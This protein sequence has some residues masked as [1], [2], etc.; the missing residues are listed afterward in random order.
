MSVS[1]SPLSASSG[2][3]QRFSKLLER[4]QLTSYDRTQFESHRTTVR[5]AIEERL[6][7]SKVDLMGSFA[8]GTAIHGVSDVDLLVVLRKRTLLW[9]DHLKTSNT[10]LSEVREAI[11]D[12]FPH[13][14]VSRDCQ[15]IVAAFSDGT[16][17]V[18]IVPAYYEDQAGEQNNP[19]YQIPDGAGGWMRTSPG[20]H[21]RF[22][23]DADQRAGGQLKYVGQL[24]KYWRTTRSSPVP[25][26]GFHVELLLAQGELCQGPRSY[27][28]IFR[29]LLVLLSKRNCAA[30]RD[31][32]GISGYIPACSSDPKRQLACRTVAE[33]AAH[34]DSALQG[35]ARGDLREA[36]RQ[37]NIVFNGSF[38]S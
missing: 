38:P 20:S 30:L 2:V 18:D 14:T 11:R 25:I 33:A 19:R 13:T 16:H 37:W 10:V 34:A 3:F 22:L 26:S 6:D 8:R 35:E 9:G 36:L 4:M 15:A 24:F 32:V 31:P 12:R 7:T 21:N 23:S 1:A 17:P 5:L 28:Q 29:D 27:A